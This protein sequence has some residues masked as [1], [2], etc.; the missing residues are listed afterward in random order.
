MVVFPWYEPLTMGA[1]MI[2]MFIAPIQALITL[3]LMGSY[4]GSSKHKVSNVISIINTGILFFTMLVIII[5]EDLFYPLAKIFAIAEC[6]L[7]LSY[8]ITI[9][10][11]LARKSE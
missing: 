3:I 9:T 2:L 10:K 8:T 1:V 6:L 11:E 5:N 4:R 7:A